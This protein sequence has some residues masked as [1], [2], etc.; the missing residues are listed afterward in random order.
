M[1]ARIGECL[2]ALDAGLLVATV[3]VCVSVALLWRCFR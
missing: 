1:I 3:A 2:M